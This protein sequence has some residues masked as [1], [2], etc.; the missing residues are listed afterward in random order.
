VLR[1]VETIE[2]ALWT[3]LG[4]RESAGSERIA[5][6][7]LGAFHS[8]YL[9]AHGRSREAQAK[10]RERLGPIRERLE[11]GA[12][13]GLPERY[14]IDADGTAHPSGDPLSVLAATELLR[15]WVEDLDHAERLAARS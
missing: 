8:A 9:R 11:H 13:C 5:P 7:W 3:P 12:G 10:V 2:A 6:E 14:R 4:L 1:L 15:L